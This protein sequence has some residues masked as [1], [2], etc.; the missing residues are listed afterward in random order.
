[1]GG[2][3]QSQRQRSR[4]RVR[5]RRRPRSTVVLSADT[6]TLRLPAQ[7][8]P[9]IESCPIRYAFERERRG[10][11]IEIIIKDKDGAELKRKNLTIRDLMHGGGNRAGTWNWD[12]KDSS[13][14]YV[15]PLQSPLAVQIRHE[16][17]VAVTRNINI[18]IGQITLWADAY[19][20]NNRLMMN[21]PDHK[22]TVFATV[23]LKKID[24]SNT[25]TRIPIDVSFSFE[26]PNPVNTA[27]NQSFKY[28]T[29]PDKYLGK[30]G[31]NAA[32]HWEADSSWTTTSSDAFKTKCKVSVETSPGTTLSKAKVFFKPSAVG[33]DSFK[34]K[35]T[36]YAAD[37]TT[38]LRSRTSVT[39]RAWRS[40]AFDDIYE[41]NGETAVS[42]NG[43]TAIISPVFNPAFVRYTAGAPK[44]LSATAAT[45]STLSVK[46]IGLWGGIATPQRS[47]VTL[48]R[49]TAAETPTADEIAKA[50]YAGADA[51][52]LA[53]R[54]TA[55]TAINA[56]A[57]AW[58]TRIDTRFH[59]DMPQ[60]VTD[61]GLPSHS[62]VSIKYY[63][64]KYSHR[65]GDFQTNQWRL[66]GAGVPAWLRVGAFPRS[67]GGHY[68]TNLDPDGLWVNWGGLS[69]G[70]GRVSVPKG[71]SSATTKQ[72]V[73]HE[74][75]H[76]T[77]FSF[78]RDVFGPSLDH[79]ASI[80]GIMY[81]T[82]AGGTTFT[83]REKKILRGI[84]P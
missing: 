80:A 71:N 31:D 46:Y 13:G 58:A 65:G 66:G 64:P 57:Q 83:R 63:H 9:S 73:R 40:V 35:A 39:L 50:T 16:S 81:F 17:G 62:L 72:V 43:T 10:S 53:Q 54:A 76:A 42:S 37:G 84:V 47:W 79:S 4:S 69:H 56:K 70:N 52:R 20:S 48:Q 59:A 8:A 18:T 33:G 78:K 19:S 26:D 1:M 68:Y 41:M 67:G 3:A 55:R 51:A 2:G 61:A 38:V 14:N 24:G 44:P 77:K 34:L 25:R 49:K 28:Q 82:T 7:F 36:V 29:G 75:G 45:A 15:T 60:W 74:A 27:K 12:G 23:Y 11:R 22:A 30:Q 6:A 32:L 21:D 5:R